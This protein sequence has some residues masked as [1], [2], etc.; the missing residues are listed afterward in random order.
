MPLWL[1]LLDA[2]GL[3][4]APRPA[5]RCSLL[6]VRRRV[7]SR[8]GG[9][10][11]LSHRLRPDDEPGRGWL[12]GLGRY[13]GDELEWFRIFTLVAAAQA[14]LE[15]RPAVLRRSRVS[16]TGPER[17]VLY[18]DHVV[19]ACAEPARRG[20]AG[21]EPGVA[22]RVPG[23]ARV[24][25][26]RDGLVALTA[27]PRPCSRPATRSCWRS[28]STASSSPPWSPGSRTCARGSSLDN[29][30]LGL[31]LLAIAAGSIL[32]LPSSGR[33]DPR[34][35]RRRGGPARVRSAAP[36]VCCVAALGA[37]GVSAGRRSRRSA[38]SPTAS[39]PASGTSR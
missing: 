11:E 5:L 39:A 8:H 31:L 3:L 9:T 38:C 35:E 33:A 30:A 27:S 6:V 24:A 18:P 13:S 4:V 12:L 36:S 37:G 21:D 17:T 34:V 1:V 15:P 19:I 22:D 29:G 2:A 25:A 32:A 26:A 20:R 16:P 23:L 10:F 7:L 28:C 14:G